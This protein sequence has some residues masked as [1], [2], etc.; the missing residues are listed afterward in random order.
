VL[1][2]VGEVRNAITA[3]LQERLRNASLKDGLEAAKVAL[4]VANDKYKAGL[5]NFDT[6]I[7]AQKS[8]AD[9]VGVLRD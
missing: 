9:A 7:N 4:L 3:S 6:V 2:A 8:S 1:N 5:T